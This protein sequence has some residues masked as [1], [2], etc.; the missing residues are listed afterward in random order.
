MTR[1]NMLQP[2]RSADPL[3]GTGCEH[4]SWAKTKA[5]HLEAMIQSLTLKAPKKKI[6][7]K[8]SSAEVVC[9]K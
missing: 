1:V 4:P 3:P 9:C 7:L 2:N 6:H 8:K 5:K